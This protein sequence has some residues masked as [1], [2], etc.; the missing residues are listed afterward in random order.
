MRNMPVLR[1]NNYL[2]A[3]GKDS[4][5]VRSLF[6]QECAKRGALLL[7]THNINAAHDSLAVEQ[8]LRVYAEVC[9]TISKWLKD[10]SPERFLER[11]II[12]PVFRVR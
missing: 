8:T 12:E 4:L 10:E 2:D 9:N 5:L 1:V 6:T 3:D 11:Q 7:T